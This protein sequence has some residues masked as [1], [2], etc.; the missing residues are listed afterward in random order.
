MLVTKTT[1][2]D[3]VGQRVGAIYGKA[4]FSAAEASG[5]LAEAI[6]EFDSLIADVLD[7]QPALEQLLGNP[8]VGVDEKLGVIDHI[9]SG[10][11]SPL[12]LSFLEVLGRK[13][14]LGYLRPIL[15]QVHLLENRRQGLLSVDV[16]TATPLGAEMHDRLAEAAGEL[17]SCQVELAADVDPEM[18][19]GV[20]LKI[21]DTVYDS[22]VH[23]ELERL[24]T[25]IRSRSIDAIEAQRNRHQVEN[26]DR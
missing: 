20:I 19:G 9:F 18:I 1:Q 26:H 5:K 12:M 23:A 15:E 13:E 2:I 14:R 10:K 17:L 4:F 16:T 24:R 25:R 11:A 8:M 6:E 3:L 21:G 7:Q 22:S